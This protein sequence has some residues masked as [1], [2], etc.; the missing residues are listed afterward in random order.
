MQCLRCK[1]TGHVR[2]D[3]R[4]PRC[5]ICRRFGHRDA[6]CVR[7]YAAVTSAAACDQIE[8]Q[9]MDAAEAE[10]AAKGAGDAPS[11]LVERGPVS[12]EDYYTAPEPEEKETAK[13]DTSQEIPLKTQKANWWTCRRKRRED[14]TCQRTERPAE[15]TRA[16]QSSVRWSNLR[17][18]LTRAKLRDHQRRRHR[19]GTRASERG[20][21]YLWTDRLALQG[22]SS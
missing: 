15:S 19:G 2:R 4:V 20:P 14:A 3:C 5:S 8:E 11:S 21:I 22:T 10:D 12:P 18:L 6:Q 1:R 9:T 16:R 17:A 7:S 13:A